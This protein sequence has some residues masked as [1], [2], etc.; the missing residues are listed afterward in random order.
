MDYP[1]GRRT[2]AV[3]VERVGRW[4]KSTCLTRA[5]ACRLMLARRGEPSVVRLGVAK[6]GDAFAA[7]AWLESGAEILT[8]ADGHERFAVIASFVD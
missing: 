1:L 7:H 8:G 3:A 4:T 5:L 6:D 2:N